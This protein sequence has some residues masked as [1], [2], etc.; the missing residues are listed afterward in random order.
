MRLLWVMMAFFSVVILVIT[1]GLIYSKSLER[2][3]RISL[4]DLELV[5]C[6]IDYPH[7]FAPRLMLKIRN[8][9]TKYTL[10]S[11]M[12]RI[13]ILDNDVEKDK[14]ILQTHRYLNVNIRPGKS[15]DLSE[16]FRI[17]SGRRYTDRIRCLC[18]IVEG[19]GD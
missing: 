17:T 18:E 16:F 10:K 14:I 11:I 7:A 12:L 19:K 8:K 15:G 3:K 1:K 6:K 4:D 9:S 5:D 13:R 2:P